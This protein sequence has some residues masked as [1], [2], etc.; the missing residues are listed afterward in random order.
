MSGLYNPQLETFVRAADTGGFNKEEYGVARIGTL[1]MTPA[2][3]LTDLLPQIHE[4]RG[5]V[6]FQLVPFENTPD[7]AEKPAGPRRLKERKRNDA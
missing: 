2:Q 7:T 1:P 5:D 3:L 6:S 4:R